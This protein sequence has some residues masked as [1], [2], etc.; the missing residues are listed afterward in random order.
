MQIRGRGNT[1][2][3]GQWGA[4]NP[5]RIKLDEHTRV[6]ELQI[7]SKVIWDKLSESDQQII[8]ECAKESALL[9]RRLWQEREKTSRD[10]AEKRGTTVIS[11]TDSEKKRFRNAMS[12][13]YEKYAGDQM[14]IIR[15]ITEY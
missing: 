9:E 10:I 5:Y 4:K 2:W 13:V 15:K 6:P 3:E 8:M 7:C 12:L 1:T 11:L 14:D